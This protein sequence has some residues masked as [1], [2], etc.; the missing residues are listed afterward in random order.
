MTTTDALAADAPQGQSVAMTISNAM[1][2]PY[3]THL[4]RG[5]TKVRTDF[6]G[7]D[8]LL[9]TLE[10]SLTPAER[11][12]AKMG[13]EQRLR[14]IRELFQYASEDEFRGIVEKATGRKVRAFISGIDVREDV[15]VELFY[16][17]PQGE[18]S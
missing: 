10:D 14:D 17:E 5:P 3:K 2:R 18:E 7:P 15:S 9:C 8:T 1:V 6:A 4:G 16:L 12:L 11:N 13:E